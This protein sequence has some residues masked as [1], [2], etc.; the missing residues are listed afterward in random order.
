MSE[1]FNVSRS[2]F[3][4]WAK[5]WKITIWFKRKN[6]NFRDF[7]VFDFALYPRSKTRKS[8]KFFFTLNYDTDYNSRF[9]NTKKVNWDKTERFQ[10][11]LEQKGKFPRFKFPRFLSF[12]FYSIPRSK[13]RKSQKILFKFK[14]WQ[15]KI[16]KDELWFKKQKLK[17]PRFWFCPITKIELLL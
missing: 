8:R 9:E 3:M 10:Y 5:N 15:S 17:L 16:Q 2:F 4:N 7:R 12:W 6:K 11:D 13:T 14:F 1:S